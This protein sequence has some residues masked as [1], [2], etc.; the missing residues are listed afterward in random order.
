[1]LS[2]RGGEPEDDTRLL[3]KSLPGKSSV[4]APTLKDVSKTVIKDLLDFLV[5]AEPEEAGDGEGGS[6]VASSKDDLSELPTTMAS[7]LSSGTVNSSRGPAVIRQ[8]SNELIVSDKKEE[9]SKE[10]KES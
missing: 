6:D 8:V 9:A 5:Q 3:V 2:K 7:I 10:T 4:P 1:M